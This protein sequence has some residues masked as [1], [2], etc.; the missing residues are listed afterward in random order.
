MSIRLGAAQA[1]AL[2][3]LKTFGVLRT[4]S[5]F[6]YQAADGFDT[7]VSKQKAVKIL[8]SLVRVGFAEPAGRPAFYPAY[9]ITDAGL[10]ALEE[11]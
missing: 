1:G 7:H 9:Q 6:R 2:K 10:K 11:L 4:Q 5:G 8:E 3:T